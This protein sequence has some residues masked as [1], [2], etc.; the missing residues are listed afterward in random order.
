MA[1]IHSHLLWFGILSDVLN[2]A[3]ALV[4]G[5]DA[6]L[7]LRDVA[8]KRLDEQFRSTFPKLNLTDDDWETALWSV[9]RALAGTVLLLA[10]FFV[11]ILLRLAETR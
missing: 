11:Q 10:G 6:F 8:N 4:L 5:Y 3:G 7:R 1:L 2:F 9:R